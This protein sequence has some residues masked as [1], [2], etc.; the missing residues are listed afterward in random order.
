VD[1]EGWDRN[2]WKNNICLVRGVKKQLACTVPRRS[3]LWKFWACCV[4]P[5]KAYV[6]AGFSLF[7]LAC[8]AQAAQGCIVNCESG[9]ALSIS[10]LF[11]CASYMTFT[12]HPLAV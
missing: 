3:C 4:Y 9:Y 6:V 8:L 7:F 12:F 1:S 11:C 5:I 2:G 10:V